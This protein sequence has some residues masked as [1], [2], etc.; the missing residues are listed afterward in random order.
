ME[1]TEYKKTIFK[2]SIVTIIWNSILSVAKVAIGFIAG[3][4]SLISDGF[5]SLSDVLSTI[6]VMIG[7]KISTKKED[8]GHPFGHERFE[9]VASIILALL[10]FDTALILGYKGVLSIIDFANGKRL[11]STGFIYVAL[12]CAIASI[13]IKFFMYLY[14]I[15]NAKRINSPSLKADGYHHLSDSLSSIGSV[16]GIIG[17]IVGGNLELFDPIAS[18]LIAL[19]I[20]KVSIDIFKDSINQLVDKAAPSD[21]EENIKNLVMTCEGV[22]AINSLKTRMFA[23]KLYVELEI[24]VD[25]NITVKEGHEIAKNVHDLIESSNENVKHCM[26]HVDPSDYNWFN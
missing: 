7:A 1:N 9:S 16:V 22:I 3:A 13:V 4:V 21:V 12:G 6:I 11:E 24:V 23:N 2:V 5:H 10:L 8:K 18:I 19:F 17:L 20:V 14:T 15:I 26:V 25:G